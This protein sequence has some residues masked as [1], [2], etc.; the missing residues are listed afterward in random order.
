LRHHEPR[1]EPFHAAK[2]ACKV[3]KLALDEMLFRHVVLVHE[4][5]AA[6]II[7]SA[8]PVIQ[9]VD[10]GVEL[11]VRADRH[12]YELI[13]FK[14]PPREYVHCEIRLSRRRM[15]PPLITGTV[16]QIKGA[17]FYPLIE[18]REARDNALYVIANQVVVARE[19]I[20]FG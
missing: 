7:D 11:I 2:V 18:A 17:L 13:R 19:F 10:R 20:H 14:R 1:R 4:Y 15:E 9:A 5:D 6:T 16:R 3:D 8:V 12:H